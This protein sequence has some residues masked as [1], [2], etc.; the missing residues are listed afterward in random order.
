MNLLTNSIFTYVKIVANKF[1]W[2]KA[3]T[4]MFLFLK[5]IF[6]LLGAISLT[7]R[8]NS[9]WRISNHEEFNAATITEHEISQTFILAVVFRVDSEEFQ[10]F[11]IFQVTVASR[12]V[13]KFLILRLEFLILRLEYK[14][15]MPTYSAGSYTYNDSSTVF[16]CGLM[17]TFVWNFRL[18]FIIWDLADGSSKGSWNKIV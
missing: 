7:W 13:R 1:A 14:I 6:S 2:L 17:K 15:G 16:S 10:Y 18:K 12:N 11:F 8:T 3:F 9:W 5:I 4:K